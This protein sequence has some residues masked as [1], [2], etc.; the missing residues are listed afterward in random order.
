MRSSKSKWITIGVCIALVLIWKLNVPGQQNK[1]NI[2]KWLPPKP[3]DTLTP[4]QT[5]SKACVKFEG[6]LGNLLFKYSSLFGIA[7]KNNVNA[8]VPTT[9]PLLRMF[10][11]SA[12]T[13][14]CK[15]VNNFKEK[16]GCT[17]ERE[18]M[19]IGGKHDICLTGYYQS[20]KYFNDSQTELRK[21]LKFKQHIEINAREQLSLLKRGKCDDSACVLI[22]V[23]VRRGDFVHKEHLRKYGYTS[24]D[25]NYYIKAMKYFR[26]KFK[27]RLFIVASD[28]TAWC[29]KHINGDDVVFVRRNNTPE[30]DMAILGM[31]KNTVMSVGSFSWWAAWFAGGEAVYYGGYPKPGSELAS[32]VNEQD[33]RLPGSIKM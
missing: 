5:S 1:Y 13:G 18:V 15:C 6:R 30:V 31:C 19:E 4:V 24:P 10:H 32:L 29:K 7:K 21:E 12:Q 20:W 9:L 11:L 2:I 28:D 8:T 27:S 14:S 16:K 23:H 17:F 22:G 26:D 33:Y 3:T 25:K